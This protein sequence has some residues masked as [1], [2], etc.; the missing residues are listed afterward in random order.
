[1]HTSRLS[2]RSNFGM[3]SRW[4]IKLIH[5]KAKPGKYVG[6]NELKVSL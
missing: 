3:K 2:D 4:E 6:C 5:E 1:M